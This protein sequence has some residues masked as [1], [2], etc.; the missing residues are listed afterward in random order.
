M[1]RARVGHVPLA[2]LAILGIF[3]AALGVG[4]LLGWMSWHIWILGLLGLSTGLLIGFVAAFFRAWLGLSARLLGLVGV[5]ALPLA[6]GA[7]LLMED[8]NHLR[9]WREEVAEVR[10]AELGLP[11]ADVEAIERAGGVSFLASDAEA[12]LDADL[13]DRLG[14]DGFQGRLL[15]R[16]DRGVRLGGG[17][18]SGRGLEL[19]RVGAVVVWLGEFLLSVALILRVLRKASTPG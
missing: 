11:P 6:F 18:R 19:G 15:Q 3:A 12:L 13:R 5:S 1:S 14:V 2:S 17:F 4:V 9:A 16:L 8:R 10:A 7:F